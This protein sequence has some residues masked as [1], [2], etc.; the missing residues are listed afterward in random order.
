MAILGSKLGIDL[1]HAFPLGHL[2]HDSLVV[3]QHD[4][5]EF[6]KLVTFQIRDQ[7]RKSGV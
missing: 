4:G 6:G 2:D 7:A 3:V 1:P 5:P